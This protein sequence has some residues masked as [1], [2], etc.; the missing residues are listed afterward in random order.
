MKLTGT[1]AIATGA[2]SDIGQAAALEL[3]CQADLS[4]KTSVRTV[5]PSGYAPSHLENNL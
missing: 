4:D 5:G 2:S 1:V 3:A